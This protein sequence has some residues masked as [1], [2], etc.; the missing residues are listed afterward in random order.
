VYRF[1]GGADGEHPWAG[2]IA[3]SSGALYGTTQLGGTS[4]I[5]TVFKLTPA[6]TSYV[7]SVLYSFTNK[8]DGGRP[9]GALVRDATGALYG[10]T[11][12]GGSPL[13]GG[14]AFKLVP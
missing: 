10:T 4:N 6:G 9:Y 12:S 2:L 11:G 13:S 7:E 1:Q 8:G 3:D 5:G 14:T